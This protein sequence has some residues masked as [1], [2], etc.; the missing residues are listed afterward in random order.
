MSDNCIFCKIAQ[1]DIPS[2]K[3]YEDD[4]IVA[5][6]DINPIAPVHFLIIPK[7]HIV[8][9]QDVAPEDGALLGRML[10]LV[11]RL[12][13]EQGC[14]PGPEGGFRLVVNNGVHGGQ[15]V[16]HLHYHVIGGP[17]PWKRNY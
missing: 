6:L 12:A 4:D 5:F 13:L 14:A 9:L 10:T 11:S 3:I 17:R 8:S 2:S 16:P 7:R 15:E 1:G